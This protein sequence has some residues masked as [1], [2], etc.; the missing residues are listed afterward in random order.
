MRS[1]NI[2]YLCFAGMMLASC[3]TKPIHPSDQHILRP[4]SQ[5]EP[6]GSIPQPIKESVILPPPRPAGKVATYSVVVT[7][8]PAQEILFALARD[9]KI[10]LDI[11][12]GIE[13]AVTVNAINQTLPQIL[14]RISRQVDMRYELD[15]GT[16][17]VMPDTPYLRQYKID[18]MNMSRDAEGGITNTS[19]VGSGASGGAAGGT[20]GGAGANSSQLSI[21][22]TSKNHF[23]DTLVQN[24]KDILHET[25]KIL[26]A[27]SSETVVQQSRAAST[28]GTGVQATSG[29]KKGSKPPGIENSPNPASLEEGG[30]TVTRTSTFREAA[31]VISN[32]ES[33]IITVRATGKQHEKIQQFI[34]QVM[35]NAR[36][37][38]MIEVTVAEVTLSKNY[39]QGIEWQKLLAAGATKGFTLTQGITGNPPPATPNSGL[40][41]LNYT[42]PTSKFG[43][44][45]ANIQLLESFGDVKV[46]SSPT[47][48]VMNNQTAMLRVVDNL[49]YFTIES[50]ASQA[51]N[52]TTLTTFTT[53]PHSVPVGLT[54]SITPEI[55]DSDTVQVNVRPSI[56][57][58]LTPVQDPNPTLA[59]PCGFGV[60]NCNLPAITSTIPQI[61]TREMESVL[62]IE[63]NQTAVLGG[64]MQDSVNNLTDSV[65]LLASIPLIGEL[66]KNRNDTT[67]K[68]ELVIFLRPTVVHGASLDEDFGRFRNSLPDK[69]FFKESAGF[70][71]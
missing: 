30:T 32:P 49:V 52:S 17:T 20:S 15:N 48:S 25:D 10:N 61:R 36:R 44:L 22:N 39:Q 2:Y 34:D 12:S 66:F 53:T 18:Y 63:N 50:T 19:Q 60:S 67:T 33:G 57:S 3:S 38:V 6:K 64:L 56:T 55:S 9:A 69:D 41:V 21:K 58:Q 5:T 1:S 46:L 62:K 45:N 51:A 8:V 70:K 16:L 71:P 59:N 11:Q 28:T 24:I 23:W 13:G 4:G 29:G 7:N 42:N 35:N 37:Q 54:M 68:T 14:D 26:P 27:G 65:P 40:F 31:A 43:N 47:L